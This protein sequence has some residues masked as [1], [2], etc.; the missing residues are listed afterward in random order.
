RFLPPTVRV[1]SVFPDVG[2]QFHSRR[3]AEAKWY[4]YTLYNHPQQSV[5]MPPDA[6]W[7]RQPLDVAHMRQALKKLEGTWDFERFKCPNTLVTDN[8]CTVRFGEVSA[9]GPYLYIDIVADRYLY[10]MVRNIVGM[11]IAVGK[12]YAN[13]PEQGDKK[14]RIFTLD[15][16]S[17]MVYNHQASGLA[18]AKPSEAV[19]LSEPESGSHTKSKP[20][21]VASNRRF[22]TAPAQGLS[23]MAIHYSDPYRFLSRLDGVQWSDLLDIPG[24]LPNN[25]TSL[26]HTF[27]SIQKAL[28]TPHTSS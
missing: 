9:Q 11:L 2:F 13:P 19:S 26:D 20:E 21:F 25:L 23:L 28:Q 22:A 10:K 4:R 18:P 15:D 5:W 1:T 27:S 17:G 7:V 14:N 6:L 12:T 24:N 16:V 8:I 3:N